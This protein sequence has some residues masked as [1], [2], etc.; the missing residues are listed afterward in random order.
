MVGLSLCAPVR[1]VMGRFALG[2]FCLTSNLKK[3]EMV[4]ST[5][6][7]ITLQ[8]LRKELGEKNHERDCSTILDANR[9]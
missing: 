7:C 6:D 9:K 3:R 2:Y 4:P 1:G 5:V 8:F